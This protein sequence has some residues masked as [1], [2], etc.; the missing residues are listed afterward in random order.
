MLSKHLIKHHKQ[1]LSGQLS[2]VYKTG[3]SLLLKGMKGNVCRVDG[4]EMGIMPLAAIHMYI[5]IYL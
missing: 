4:V 2:V 3:M 5:Y 1:C